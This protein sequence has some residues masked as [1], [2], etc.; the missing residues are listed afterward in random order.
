MNAALLSCFET[1]LVDGDVV[2]D[3]MSCFR[4]PRQT[5]SNMALRLPRR[6]DCKM[7]QDRQQLSVKV[8]ADF[9]VKVRLTFM[10]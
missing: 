9:Q 4:L 1:G 6:D 8:L 2:T 5:K 3:K 7:E 10:T